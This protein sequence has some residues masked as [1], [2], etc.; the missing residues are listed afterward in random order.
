VA[1]LG[2]VGK[3]NYKTKDYL[4]RLDYEKIKKEERLSRAVKIIKKNI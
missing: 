1:D 3:Q 4:K 2:K